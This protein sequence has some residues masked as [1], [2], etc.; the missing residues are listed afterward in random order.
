MLLAAVAALA[1]R[2]ARLLAARVT[3]IVP[4]S[5]PVA[6]VALTYGPGMAPASVIV[7]VLDRDGHGGSA[8]VPGAQLF[9]EVPLIGALSGAHCVTATAT[10]RLL[11]VPL[12]LVR[13]FAVPIG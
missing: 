7:D 12:T 10:Y 8:T 1:F 2:P 13:E 3:T 6:S 11:G 4:G 5:P 9:L